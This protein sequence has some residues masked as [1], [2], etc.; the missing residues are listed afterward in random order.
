MEKII[1]IITIAL[2]MTACSSKLMT[3]KEGVSKETTVTFSNLPSLE[4]LV[5]VDE[6]TTTSEELVGDKYI[7]TAV[8]GEKTEVLEF[9]VTFEAV[10]IDGTLPVDLSQFYSNPD[11]LAKISYVFNDDETVMTI[12]DE[13]GEEPHSFDVPVNV[14]YPSYT[15]EDDITIDIYTGYDINN[16]VTADEGVEVTSELNEN[17][18]TITLSKGIW[19]ETLERE[20]T[21]EDSSP[22]TI[23]KLAKTHGYPIVYYNKLLDYTLTF[24]D[25]NTVTL[26]DPENRGSV[27]GTRA[28]DEDSVAWTPNYTAWYDSRALGKHYYS[29]SDD[30]T[31]MYWD[32]NFMANSSPYIFE[33]YLQN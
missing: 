32:Q 16:F 29:L 10:D 28:Y 14:I 26:W 20:V 22:M 2:L 15:I 12:T 27:N 8:K 25:E 11:K 18:L 33:F 3:L 31:I 7:I 23:H 1:A 30:G 19:N 9:P 17:I 5:T 24:H 4:E 6:E 13:N 21:L